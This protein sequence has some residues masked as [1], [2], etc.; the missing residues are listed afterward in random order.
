[1][2]LVLH[3]G[4]H[5][6]GSTAFEQTIQRTI[7]QHPA[8]GVAIWGPARLRAIPGF[9][10]V[11][12][13]TH[14]IG[15]QGS[16]EQLSEVAKRLADEW[17][18]ERARGT[19][20]LI[21]SEENILGKMS[22]N[23]RDGQF[24]SGVAQRLLTYANILPSPVTTVALGIRSYSAVWSSAYFYSEQRK[25][26]LPPQQDARQALLDTDRGWYHVTRDIR[27]VFSD[28]PIVIWDQA[29]IATDLDT[30]CAAVTG[31]RTEDI[32]LPDSKINAR[33]PSK[34]Q[35]SVFEEADLKPLTQRYTRHVNRIK[36]SEGLRWVGGGA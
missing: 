27:R 17:E 4:A 20:T 8:C 9:S 33:K 13:L 23:F 2:D 7:E 25:R 11:N 31:L 29:K 14:A 3:I 18:E 10:S 30:I 5:R 15:A 16:L 32:V 34:S 12:K 26:P 36:R 6:T 22:Q 1:M 28:V 19:Q 24:Y 21:L 35:K